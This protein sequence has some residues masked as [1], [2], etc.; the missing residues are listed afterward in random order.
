M[1]KEMK[2]VET[3]TVPG[4]HADFVFTSRDQVAQAMVRFLTAGPP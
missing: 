2:Q 4:T 1:K 3:L